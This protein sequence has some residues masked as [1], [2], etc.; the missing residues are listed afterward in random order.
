MILSKEFLGKSLF[1][2]GTVI[3]SVSGAHNPPFW[4]I[5]TIGCVVA[6][7]GTILVR[8]SLIQQNKTT[9][10]SSASVD[11]AKHLEIIIQKLDHFIEDA[12]KHIPIEKMKE[13]I[14]SL[15]LEVIL[16]VTEKTNE[17]SVRLGIKNY[18][19][20]F[21][22]Y[23]QGERNLNRAWSCCADNHYEEM[24]LSLENALLYFQQSKTEYGKIEQAKA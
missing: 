2:I 6:V 3:A 17:L 20:V 15:Q 1:A 21:S 11:L 18:A 5:L 22:P 7:I 16:P 14:E 8:W 19:E 24:K 4:N 10:S 12:Q 23:A 13:T 9:S